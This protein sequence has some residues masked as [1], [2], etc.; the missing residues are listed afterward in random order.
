VF[1]RPGAAAWVVRDFNQWQPSDAEELGL[2]PAQF[3]ENRLAERYGGLAAFLK[4]DSVVDTPRC[5]RT[6]SAQAGN[7][8][9][10]PSDKF[11]QN[12]FGRAL[13]MGRFGFEENFGGPIFPPKQFGQFLKHRRGICLAVIDDPDDFSF[14]RI[15]A[16]H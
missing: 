3:H 14:Q 12:R 9:I 13:H 5:A 16:G 15:Q 2:G 11:L 1:S 8:R 4:F 6:S 10:T 7:H